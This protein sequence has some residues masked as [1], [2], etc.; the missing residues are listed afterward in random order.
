[1]CSPHAHLQYSKY[2][3]LAEIMLTIIHVQ[4]SQRLGAQAM[5]LSTEAVRTKH[6]Y[7]VQIHIISVMCDGI[8]IRL[9]QSS[10]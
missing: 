5:S 2:C 10:S 1:M 4:I 7:D 8:V 6:M 9:R 3:V